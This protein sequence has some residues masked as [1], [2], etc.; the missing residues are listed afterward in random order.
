MITQETEQ[1]ELIVNDI[2]SGIK[3]QSQVAVVLD[4]KK[5]VEQ[6]INLAKVDDVVLLAGKGHEDYMVIGTETIAY[7]ERALVEQLYSKAENMRVSL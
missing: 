5:A 3:Q 7:D 4:R 2:L 1:A 6:A